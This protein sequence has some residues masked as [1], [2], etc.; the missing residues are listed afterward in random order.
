M[1]HEERNKKRNAKTQTHSFDLGQ[2]NEQTN[3]QTTDD[4]HISHISHTH[5]SHISHISQFDEEKNKKKK[6]PSTVLFWFPLLCFC[7]L[8]SKRK[9]GLEIT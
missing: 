9:Q 4:T 7:L 8:L 6:K 3:E 1:I 5:I 2:I